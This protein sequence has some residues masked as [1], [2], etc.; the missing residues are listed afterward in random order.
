M[1]DHVDYL[2]TDTVTVPGQLY[3]L[4]SFVSPDSNQKNDKVGMKIRGCFATADEANAHVRRLMKADGTVDVYLVEMYK[5]V[6][7]PPDPDKIDDHRYQEEFLNQMM[8]EYKRSQLE[9]KRHFEER[10]RAV[11]EQGLDANLLPTERLPPP[12]PSAIMKD[13][14]EGP[15]GSQP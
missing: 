6:L 4:V 5:W 7:V 3:A 11:M 12:T 9:A 15:S 1:A 2:E 10:K 8:Q 14:E 13:L